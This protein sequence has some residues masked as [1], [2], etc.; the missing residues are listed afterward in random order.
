MEDF[1]QVGLADIKMMQQPSMPEST[2]THHTDILQEIR[3][4]AHAPQ[5][6]INQSSF[7]DTWG[8]NYAAPDLDFTFMSGKNVQHNI[9][10]DMM[11][12]STRL[13]DR[14]WI[15]PSTSSRYIEIS[16]LDEAFKTERMVENLRWVGMSN[17]DLEKVCT[18]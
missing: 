4:V 10:S 18:F 15:D 1:P 7:Q 9:L 11:M 2:S 12:N 16:D 5:E 13:A 6:L 17:D 8:G 3:S 14:S